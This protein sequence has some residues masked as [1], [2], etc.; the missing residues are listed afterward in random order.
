LQL[1]LMSLLSRRFRWRALG[2]H[3]EASRTSR[4]GHSQRV[5]PESQSSHR[6]V[7]RV[8]PSVALA[9]DMSRS[10]SRLCQI[11]EQNDRI[12]SLVGGP[13]LVDDGGGP[14]ARPRHTCPGRGAP[15][16]VGRATP[17]DLATGV[18]TGIRAGLALHSRPLW[19]GK[20]DTKCYPRL[21]CGQWLR[22]GAGKRTKN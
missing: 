10:T 20:I 18:C 17:A 14:E 13:P 7:S 22:A 3:R 2:L 4:L 11:S 21:H 6:T 1:S 19:D 16:G 5:T 8:P 15:S 9:P 12:Y